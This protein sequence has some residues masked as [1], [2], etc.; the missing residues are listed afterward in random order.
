[1]VGVWRPRN[2]AVSVTRV[3]I[4]GAGVAGVTTATALRQQG[5][6]GEVTLIDAGEFAYDRPPLSKGFLTGSASRESLAFFSQQWFADNAITYLPNAHVTAIDRDVLAVQTH[7]GTRIKGDMIVLATGGHALVPSLLSN[8][9]GR[10]HVLRTI[11]DAE[12]LRASLEAG[13]RLLVIGAGLLG[14]EI[15][16]SAHGMGV[17]VAT[18][19]PA[20][21]PLGH[22]VGERLGLWLR[23]R[24]EGF[25]ISHTTAS[26]AAVRAVEHAVTVELAN[27]ET[28][29]ADQVVLAIGLRPD[30]TLAQ[31]A[32]LDVDR[33]VLVDERQRTSDPRILAIGDCSADAASA[34]HRAAGHWDA[35]KASGERAAATILGH[36]P[37]DP[38]VSWFWSDRGDVRLDVLGN[39][40]GAERHIDRGAFGGAQFMVG[41][42]T[43]GILTSAACV[44][45][46]KSARQ[47]RKLLDRA[48]RPRP[49]E[50]ADVSQTLKQLAT[51]R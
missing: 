23:D 20:A 44:N 28:L 18:I 1:M 51:A 38:G 25:G 45:D 6:V 2:E 42:F 30:T 7:R 48:W 3:V 47:L 43:N 10:V 24:L 35:A 49:E 9:S 39:F 34:P 22:L 26:V 4:V 27:G 19:D 41:G 37:A 31:A 12:R 40:A 5:F 36:E 11:E 14:A 15:A 46:P 32:G 50:F 17:D 8:D 21:V 33:A 16:I 13:T 29:A